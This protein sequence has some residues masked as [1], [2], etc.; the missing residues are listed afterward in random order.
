MIKAPSKHRSL[1]ALTLAAT[2]LFNSVDI[3]HAQNATPHIDAVS[4]TLENLAP[5]SQGSVWERT[6]GNQIV[7]N[8]AFDSS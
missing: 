8:G 7:E 6:T 1:C 3:T 4:Q 5:G 2:T